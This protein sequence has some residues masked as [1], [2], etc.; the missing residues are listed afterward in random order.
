MVHHFGKCGSCCQLQF[1]FHIIIRLLEAVDKL[2]AS[3]LLQDFRCRSSHRVSRRLGTAVSD[4]CDPLVMDVS[5][6]EALN[7]LKVL[8]QVATFHK[9]SLLQTAVEELMV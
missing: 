5:R 9:F 7:R 2:N 1:M 4:L 3:Y 6:D 8:R